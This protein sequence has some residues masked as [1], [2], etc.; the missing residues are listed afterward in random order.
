M[1]LL[2]LLLLALP[3]GWIVAG[4][5]AF[6]IGLRDKTYGVPF[7]AIALN[8]MW[9]LIGATWYIAS[10]GFRPFAL[11][12]LVWGVL[13]ILL[14]ITYFKFGYSEFDNL[15]GQNKQT[16]IGFSILLF[17]CAGAWQAVFCYNS[18][19]WLIDTAFTQM[20]LTSMMFVYMLFARRSSRGQSMLIAVAKCIGS[21][22][23]ALYGWLRM[24]DCF[25]AGLGTICFVLDCAYIV[26]LYRM[27]QAEK[28]A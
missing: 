26:L 13:D 27:I 23:P 2:D 9:V 11:T 21:L 19:L 10:M 3:V 20:I 25:M 22:G 15:F 8:T 18:E 7:V 6:R 12:F 16:F 28:R 17:L 5:D 4:L 14:L 1:Q 24:R